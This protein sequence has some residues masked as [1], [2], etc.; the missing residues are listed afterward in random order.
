MATFYFL[1]DSGVEGPDW[2]DL[3]HWWMDAGKVT[4]ASTLP[5]PSDD[6]VMTGVYDMTNSGAVPTV[7]NLTN[8]S[9]VAQIANIEITVTGVATMNQGNCYFSI[10][11]NVVANGG[12]Y[13]AGNID[14]NLTQ[15]GGSTDLAI[16]VTGNAT[17][18]DAE[19]FATIQGNATFT[20]VNGYCYNSGTVNEDATFSTSA[21][22][23]AGNNG[24]VGGDATFN[25]G[26][27]NTG[28][29][30]GNA[31]FKGGNSYSYSSAGTGGIGG[32]ATFEG[33]S[34]L[35][36]PVGGNATFSDTSYIGGGG[37]VAGNATFN[38]YAKNAGGVVQ[39]NATFNDESKNLDFSAPGTVLGNATFNDASSN[40]IGTYW[41]FGRTFGVV[42][43]N[44]TFTASSFYIQNSPVG[45][46]GGVVT[47]NS[48]TPVRFTVWEAWEDSTENW[49]FSTPGQNWLFIGYGVHNNPGN[50][51]VGT[52]RFRDQ[53]FNWKGTVWGDAIFSASCAA[54]Q[55]GYFNGDA[56]F[57]VTNGNIYVES[58][59]NGSSILGVV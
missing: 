44:A 13:V 50:Y 7:A 41:G 35:Y 42:N 22:G 26:S 10:N 25:E 6:V 40:S 46:V 52:V 54:F 28:T 4:G 18:T 2:Q 23:N 47:F 3:N 59:I 30:A 34:Q 48:A 17:F 49:V 12:V 33:D 29:V 20:A 39:G 8:N 56:Q 19:N 51:I 15:N 38:D 24:T 58:G 45:S 16:T 11:G 53:S 1:P 5:G 21:Y 43:G 57:A 31:T 37:N 36:D 55:L 14:G 9:D 27:L 32:N